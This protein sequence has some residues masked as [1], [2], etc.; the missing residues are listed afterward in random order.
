MFKLKDF[1]RNHAVI[2]AVFFLFNL[3]IV[4]DTLSAEEKIRGKVT[5]VLGDSVTIE[6]DSSVIPVPEDRVEI[7]FSTPDGD[8]IPVGEWRVSAVSGRKV[9]AVKFKAEGEAMIDMSA[10]IYSNNP[11][12]V[13]DIDSS[14]KKKIKDVP[15]LDKS[16]D[17][18]KYLQKGLDYTNGTNVAKDPAE[19][20]RWFNKAAGVGN[21]EAQEWVAWSYENGAGTT[22]DYKKAAQWYRKVA[23]RGGAFA[24]NRLGRMYES[25]KGVRQ[26]YAE[27]MKWYR[28]A[29]EQN[30]A[31]GQTN[32]GNMYYKSKDYKEALT[33][34]RKAAAQGNVGAMYNIGLMY[35]YG[36]GVA[37]DFKAAMKWYR[38]AAEL[39]SESSMTKI[40]L[41]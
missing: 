6:I 20:F 37:M 14:R 7:G 31:A 38:K 15:G 13:E 4:T 33:W 11:Q 17:A 19:A 3:F 10:V 5:A 35:H 12:K 22:R 34:F 40:G 39:G 23:E 29:A 21:R 1:Y 32:L 24:Q 8:Y 26:D 30:H 36:N 28:K 9:E 27:A 18:E 16:T 41:F 2:L 25:G